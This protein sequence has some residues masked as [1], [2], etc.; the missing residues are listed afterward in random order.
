[1]QV[2]IAG[3]S[4]PDYDCLNLTLGVQARSAQH[5]TSVPTLDA[6]ATAVKVGG[7]SQAA[8]AQQ[9]GQNWGT[10][11]AP[12]RPPAPTYANPLTSR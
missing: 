7:F 12:Y 9:F 5:L 10:S 4:M 1:V 2:T 3:Q 11:T 6:S 8:L